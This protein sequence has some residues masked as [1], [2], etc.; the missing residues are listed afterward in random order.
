MLMLE[1]SNDRHIYAQL[2]QVTMQRK[3]KPQLVG[4][5]GTL[6]DQSSHIPQDVN[7]DVENLHAL[8]CVPGHMLHPFN[9]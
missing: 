2:H 5:G 8:G 3:E 7:L 6:T 1:L 9:W 4:Q